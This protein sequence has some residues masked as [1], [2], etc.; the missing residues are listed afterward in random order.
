[1]GN[2]LVQPND[3]NNYLLKIFCTRLSPGFCSDIMSLW[4]VLVVLLHNDM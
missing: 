1:M 2:Y 3:D 4:S